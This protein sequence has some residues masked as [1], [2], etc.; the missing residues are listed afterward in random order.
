[1]K[2]ND[3]YCFQGLFTVSIAAFNNLCTC[4]NY[5]RGFYFSELLQSLKFLL[6]FI[7]FMGNSRCYKTRYTVS[8]LVTDS[9]CILA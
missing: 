3:V 8:P 1:M 9:M 5:K 6:L 7:Y 4:I 2:V